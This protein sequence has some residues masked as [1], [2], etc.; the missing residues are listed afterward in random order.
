METI[1]ADVGE[2]ITEDY[3]TEDYFD[4]ET[5]TEDVFDP[6]GCPIAMMTDRSAERKKAWSDNAWTVFL[7]CCF[8]YFPVIPSHSICP[9]YNIEIISWYTGH[10]AIV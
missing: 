3:G 2:V 8:P 6:L 1:E 4:N 5:S 10:T 7:I 9:W